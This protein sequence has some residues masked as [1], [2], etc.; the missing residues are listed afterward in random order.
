[1]LLNILQCIGHSPTTKNYMI[2]SI[3]MAEVNKS[4]INEYTKS[5]LKQK[6]YMTT[7]FNTIFL[8]QLNY[9]LWACLFETKIPKHHLS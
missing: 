4:W 8:V 5:N 3:R 7:F 2:C 6:S 9:C 1:M